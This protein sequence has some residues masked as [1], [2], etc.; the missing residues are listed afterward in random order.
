MKKELTIKEAYMAM[1]KYLDGLYDS[2]KSEDLGDFLSSMQLLDDGMPVDSAV[3][4]DW[5]D[6]VKKV[7]ENMK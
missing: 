6:A 7:K 4:E 3:W 2:T 5:L 1:F